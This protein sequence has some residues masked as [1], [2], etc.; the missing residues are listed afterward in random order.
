MQRTQQ[1]G[2]QRDKDSTKGNERELDARN[3]DEPLLLLYSCSITVQGGGKDA[4]K[5]YILPWHSLM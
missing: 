1:A 2:Q 5:S 4:D 3:D